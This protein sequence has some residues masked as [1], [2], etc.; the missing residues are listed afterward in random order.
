MRVLRFELRG[1]MAHFRKYYSNSTALSYSL[2]PVT[3]IKGML[4]GLLGMERGSYYNLFSNR[5]CKIAVGTGSE[6]RKITQTMNLLKIERLDDLNGSSRP[7]GVV[8]GANHTQNDTEWL[9]PKHIQKD[10]LCF[11]VC[12]RHDDDAVFD[13]LAERVCNFAE[14]YGSDGISL[15]LGSAQCLGW[16]SGG[17]VREAVQVSET[18][19]T[20]HFAVPAEYISGFRYIP[21]AQTALSVFKEETF[22]EFDENR[23]LTEYSKMDMISSANG[24]DITYQLRPNV[25]FWR[26]GRDDYCFLG[27]NG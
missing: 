17:E 18:L 6:V 4:A 10:S 22:T 1:K 7:K 2:P 5:K 19:L 25:T 27:E 20:T 24:S 13:A 14:G 8:Y 9:I 26:D 3:T 21:G 15:A 23:F 11:P 12:V 16:I